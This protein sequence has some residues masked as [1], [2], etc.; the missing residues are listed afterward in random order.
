MQLDGGNFFKKRFLLEFDSLVFFFQHFNI[1]QSQYVFWNWKQIFF[2]FLS[3]KKAIY[4]IMAI[5]LI[6]E[7]MGS[8]SV[9][10]FFFFGRNI[11]HEKNS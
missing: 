10:F 4:F 9:K 6:Q 8:S 3:L 1:N 5:S 11:I 7:L 2:E